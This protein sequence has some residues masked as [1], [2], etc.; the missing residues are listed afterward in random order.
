VSAAE[1]GGGDEELLDAVVHE[2][3][4]T[5]SSHAIV[6]VSWLTG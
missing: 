2:K 1:D 3:N 5:A 4:A 6:T